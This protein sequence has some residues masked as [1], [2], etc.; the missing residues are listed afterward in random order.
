MSLQETVRDG[1]KGAMRAK[2]QVRLDTLRGLSAAFTNEAVALGKTPQTPITDEEAFAV[3]RRASK[4]RR[5]AIEQFK[6][7]GR[8]DLAA[9]E[10]AQLTVV[11]SFLPSMMPREQVLELARAKAAELGVTYRADAGKLMSALMKDLR[12]KADGNDVKAAVDSLLS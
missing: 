5:D 4:Q 10:Q 9:I 3:L 11:E 12:G 8:N 7:G 6:A 2:D 1:I